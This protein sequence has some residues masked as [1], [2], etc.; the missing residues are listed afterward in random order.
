[1]KLKYLYLIILFIILPI[2]LF[3]ESTNTTAITKKSSTSLKLGITPVY[4][5]F[6]E[7]YPVFFRE[8]E[9]NLIASFSELNVYDKYFLDMSINSV[10]L[11]KF[12]KKWRQPVSVE[13]KDQQRYTRT[14]EELN[15]IDYCIY[16]EIPVFLLTGEEDFYDSSIIRN[17][18]KFEVKVLVIETKTQAVVDETVLKINILS[19]KPQDILV[20]NTASQVS[21]KF[22]GFINNSVYLQPGYLME[23]KKTLF[24]WINGGYH[25]GIKR[26]DFYIAYLD[27]VKFAANSR[28][29][30]LIKIVKTEFDRSLGII[31][32]D[33]PGDQLNKESFTFRKIRKI[34]LE[35]QAAGG[36]TIADLESLPVTVLPTVTIRGLIPVKAVFFRPVIQAEFHFLFKN[37]SLLVPFFVET[38]FQGDF[39]F[40]RAAISNGFLVGAFFSPDL[41]N[42]YQI[43]SFVLIPYLQISGLLNHNLRLFGEFGYRYMPDNQFESS[44]KIDLSGV[45]FNAGISLIF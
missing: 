33:A 30:V 44:W 11:R 41:T 37:N 31:L 23:E 18:I 40:H 4:S 32:I 39:Y 29:R 35:I 5:T 19:E 9:D 24:L 34:D 2:F 43:D 15:S 14:I 21:R 38:G 45:Y 22:T 13:I 17:R 6:R 10:E 16:L 25:E 27:E 36:P 3:P 26:G 7:H 20:K 8:I 28:K 12:L 42:N 1:M